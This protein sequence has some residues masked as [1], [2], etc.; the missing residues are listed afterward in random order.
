MAVVVV[1]VA[2]VM[3][4]AEAVMGEAEAEAVIHL[5]LPVQV[6][7]T[8]LQVVHLPEAEAQEEIL[9]LAARAFHR[10]LAQEVLAEAQH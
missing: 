4:E 3:G 9:E 2:D 1:E 8:V 5:L 10:T 6:A 7:A